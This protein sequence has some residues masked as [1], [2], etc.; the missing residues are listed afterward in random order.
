MQHFIISACVAGAIAFVPLQGVF[1]Q[2]KVQANDFVELFEK[3]G[4][5]H[6]GFRVAHARGVCASGRF[7]PAGSEHFSQ[8]QLLAN[9][10]LPVMLRFSVGGANPQ[11]DERAPGTR[12]VGIQIALPNGSN[13]H[14]TGNNFPVFAGKD[15]DTFFGFLSTLLPDESGRYDPGKTLAY[16]QQN[17]SVQ[18]NAAWQKSAQTA[19]SYANTEYFGLHTFYYNNAADD[20]TRFRWHL[21]PTLGVKTLTKDEAAKQPADFLASTLD[22]QLFAGVVS[23]DL[24]ASIGEAGDSD[25]DPSIQWPDERRKVALGTITLLSSGGDACNGLNFDPNVVSAGFEP[26]A[27]P[28]LRM[29]S[30]AYAISFGKRLSNE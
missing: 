29:R 21:K 5:K 11:S 27:D 9:G 10:D 22:K 19:A 4:G 23:F 20:Q 3:L 30:T 28:V 1:A 18:A 6:P 17:P 24:E 25:I 7:S 2:T 13:H 15:P 14:F 26:S 8:A 12:G 16:V